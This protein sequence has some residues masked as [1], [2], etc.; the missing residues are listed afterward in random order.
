M[1]SKTTRDPVVQANEIKIVEARS[2][3]DPE[4]WLV[5]NAD[6]EFPLW[7]DQLHD[8]FAVLDHIHDVEHDH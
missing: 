3:E 5:S 6:D 2:D 7:L 8:L 4:Y 1:T